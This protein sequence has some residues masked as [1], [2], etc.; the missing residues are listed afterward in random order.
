MQLAR[1]QL[2]VHISVCNSLASRQRQVFA[3]ALPGDD[4]QRVIGICPTN[5][6]IGDK[7]I[8]TSGLPTAVI[9]RP[10]LD[11]LRV[12]GPV[13]LFENVPQELRNR[14]KRS[15]KEKMED[16]MEEFTLI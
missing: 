2:K 6:E 4:K 12:V 14:L 7:V 1:D 9:V 10:D 5:V 15:G 8:I 13:I 11:S 3:A 16:V